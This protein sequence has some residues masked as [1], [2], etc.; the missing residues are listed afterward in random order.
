MGKLS[1]LQ[2]V[3]QHTRSR[4]ESISSV[5]DAWA[6]FIRMLSFTVG[7]KFNIKWLNQYDAKQTGKLAYRKLLPYFDG[8]K[9]DINGIFLPAPDEDDY[10]NLSELYCCVKDVLGVYLHNND[11]YH[12]EYVDELDKRLVEGV[13]CYQNP[14]ESVEIMVNKGDVVLD[15]G[16][17]IGDFSAYASKKGA[18]VYAFEPLA[19]TR[20]MLEKT[21]LYNKDNEG[22]IYIVPLGV[23]SENESVTFYR[24]IGHSASSTFL[25]EC[26]EGSTDTVQIE[27][28]RLDDWVQKENINVNFIKA[29]IEGFEHNMLMGATKILKTQQPILSLCTYHTQNDPLVM[30]NLIL[31]ANPNYKV[32]QRRMKLFAYVP[33]QKHP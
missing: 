4:L 29:D 26:A 27:V 7:R 23:G 24:Y 17:W 14:K 16:A 21:A 30:Q 1:S 32:I 2:R 13:Y 11:D 15:L 12:Y 5:G 10:G 33:V 3:V 25:E 31:S 8:E 20:A 28:V 18:T 22:E 19:E 6:F 9:Y